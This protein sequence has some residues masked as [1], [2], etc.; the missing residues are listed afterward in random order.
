[1][2]TDEL[3]Q[4]YLTE[5]RKGWSPDEQIEFLICEIV[6]GV[7]QQTLR[8]I[9]E[10]LIEKKHTMAHIEGAKRVEQDYVFLDD[11]LSLL[12]KLLDQRREEEKND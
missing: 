2:N 11:I 9:K 8:E 5:Y 1:M 7:Y 10:K 6:D 3:K 4:K 12:D